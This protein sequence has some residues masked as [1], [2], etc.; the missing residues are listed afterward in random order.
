M[1][2]GERYRNERTTLPPKRKRPSAALFQ[3]QE[4]EK[5]AEAVCQHGTALDVHCCNCHSGFIFDIDHE[6]PE[7]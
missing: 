6:C 3:Y 2:V 1:R 7:P 5:E 4:F